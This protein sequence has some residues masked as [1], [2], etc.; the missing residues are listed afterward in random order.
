M[1]IRDS[2]SLMAFPVT[3]VQNEVDFNSHFHQHNKSEGELLFEEILKAYSNALEDEEPSL[4]N[5]QLN[6][7]ISR[8][9]KQ[10]N[11]AHALKQNKKPLVGHSNTVIAGEDEECLV[12]TSALLEVPAVLEE[13]LSGPEYSNST[14]SEPFS[15]GE[16]FSELGS[17][18]ESLCASPRRHDICRS[19]SAL[20][21]DTYYSA[22]ESPQS[23][24]SAN[25]ICR[26][27]SEKQT[28]CSLRHV[29]TRH[30]TPVILEMSDLVSESGQ[31][32]SE[33]EICE[34]EEE[35]NDL[36]IMDASSSVYDD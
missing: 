18:A 11:Y 31:E 1:C 23:I 33:E 5:T 2:A 29:R 12:D 19:R 10:S 9:L 27:E 28:A 7:S 26:A 6:N 8:C 15:S 25:S 24:K 4:V 22:Q 14:S 30:I 20:D 32:L 16:E 34:L 21:D 35:L 17:I 36:A 13:A 3:A